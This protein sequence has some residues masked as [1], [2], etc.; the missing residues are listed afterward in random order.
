MPVLAALFDFDGT[1]A[2]SF[3][4]IT[5]STN[6]VRGKYGLAP[7]PEAEVK[8]YVG[9]GLENLMEV[10]VPPAKG[11]PRRWRLIELITPPSPGK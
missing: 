9:L 1:L 11:R 8:R 6:H 5:A 10:L 2:D 3:A 4:A 7:M